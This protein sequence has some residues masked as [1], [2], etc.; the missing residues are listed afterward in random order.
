MKQY[1]GVMDIGLCI[2]GE[3]LVGFDLEI[4]VEAVLTR[5]PGFIS[6]SSLSHLRIRSGSGIGLNYLKERSKPLLITGIA[7]LESARPRQ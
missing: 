7:G 4:P 5:C 1:T 6:I 2:S 3:P